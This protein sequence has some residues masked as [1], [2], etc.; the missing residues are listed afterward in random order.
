MEQA[1][2]C[3][4]GD[5]L[6]LVAQQ[7]LKAARDSLKSQQNQPLGLFNGLSGY[8]FATRY[9]ARGGTRYRN[10]QAEIDAALHPAISRRCGFLKSQE[11]FACSDFDAISGFAGIAAYLLTRQDDP[12]AQT[13]LLEVVEFLV[14]LLGDDRKPPRWYTPS[15]LIAGESM[16][17]GFP[18]GNLNCGL[19][20]GVPGPLA[21][22]S[23]AYECG[24]R[25]PRLEDAIERAA[26]WL[27]Q[28][29]SDDAWGPNWPSAWG[30]AGPGAAPAPPVARAAWCY[31][32]P[33]IAR[34][35][36]LA[37]RALHRR[38]FQDLAQEALTAAFRRPFATLKLDS[39]MFCHGQVGVLQ[40]TWRLARETQDAALIQA[41]AF[42]TES[43]LARLDTTPDTD[44]TVAHPL[45]TRWLLEGLA[46]MALALF[47]VGESASPD[48]DR[49][50][51]LS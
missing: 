35:L 26:C 13:I 40:I 32:S 8:A 33:G 1:D 6:D 10:A 16:Q 24:V 38:E 36:W 43:I 47:T 9:L 39:P 31:G 3:F 29:R 19:A 28:N 15:H 12:G 42:L 7:H 37:G 51:L 11:Q 14:A 23:L 5:R 2:R 34:A 41:T 4:P 21:V 25:L 49:A 18:E 30:V 45:T 27:I 44:P 50:F 46:G 20:H 48:W 17:R 22:L